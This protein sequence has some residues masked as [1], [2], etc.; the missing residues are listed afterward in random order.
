MERIKSLS[1][2][3]RNA[4]QYPKD[5]TK[6][7]VPRDGYVMFDADYSQIEYR[8]LVAMAKEP[9]LA[10]MFKDPDT[11]YHTLMAS[12]MYGVPYAAVTPQMRSDAKS[13]NFGIPYGMG[14]KSLAILLTGMCGP[15]Q[16]AEAKAKYELYFKD[17]PNVK[18]FFDQV[19]EMAEVN[20]YTKTFWNRYRYYSFTDKDG[21]FSNARRA[22]ALRQAGNAVIQGCVRGDTLIQT[23][24]Y[25]IVQI[26][27]V[28]DQH[29][30]IW[31]GTKWTNG[32]ILY[33]G[34]K[35][36]CIVTFS[37][38]QRFIC[39]PTHKFL[40]R[41]HKGN[42]RF[43]ECQNIRDKS[44]GTN[45]HRVVMSQEFCDSDWA[46][47]SNWARGKYYSF[48]NNANNVFVDDIGDSFKAG[49]VLGRLASDGS[50]FLRD[51]GG[52]SIRQIIAEHEEIITNDLLEYMD[53]LNPQ[54]T[55]NNVRK[56]RNQA[57][58]WIEVYSKTLTN[59]I[60]DLDIKHCVNKK[61]FQDTEM[62]RGFLR[63]LFDGDGGITGENTI[64]LVF[65]NQYNFENMC[66]DIQKA[67]TFIG[68]RSRYHRFADRYVIDISTYDNSRF[69]DYIGFMNPE[70]HDSAVH[71][72][73]K[74]QH[75]FGRVLIVESVEITDE[76]IDMYDVCNT[77]E[78]YYV[79]DG[80]V[81]HN[82]AAD[83]FKISVARNFCYIRQNGLL[84]LALIVN[85]VHDEQLF[86][87][88]CE[89][90]NIQSVFRDIVHNME[91]HVDGFPPLYIG[92]GFGPNWKEAKGKMAEIHPALAEQLS[93]E[94][95]QA[96]IFT[97]DAHSVKEVLEYFDKRVYEFREKKVADYLMN[98]DN[99]KKDIHP[100]I[101]SL[102]NLQFTYGL[103]EKYSG[104]E[105]LLKAIEE[106]IK[107]NNIPVDPNNFR[108]TVEQVEEVEE[109]EEYDDNED[110]DIDEV[111]AQQ[112][113][114]FSL[115]DE[116]ESFFGVS[117]QDLIKEFGLVV[118]KSRRVCGIDVTILPL[119]QKD[120]LADFLATHEADKDDMESMQ[121]VFLQ[122]SNVLFN[123]GVFVK[124]FTG[125][126]LAKKLSLKTVLY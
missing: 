56:G 50:I 117:V 28:V 92:A 106:F 11:D 125:E 30:Q 15:T 21:K 101:G 123:T 9:M 17:Q 94:V 7:V 66:R 44:T 46:Y 24:E 10:E 35:R 65:G 85:M 8:T 87:L 33:S 98:P 2:N 84:G 121:V 107:R 1:D 102:I 82:T 48:S 119:K 6:L 97:T 39:S 64:R 26:Q 58:D 57:V 76:Y 5:I 96:P 100:V 88:N 95:A 118:S 43:V 45:S 14:F 81:T 40:V 69:L 22:S 61:I 126:Q 110:E 13:F 3:M 114:E 72:P 80:I 77:D 108:K 68:I 115:I 62:L 74:D 78:G 116:N 47:S 111:E 29:L 90:L 109:D 60:A 113:S 59:E 52:S 67:L 12:L 70:K 42:D 103:E 27:D 79:A 18:R 122:E 19:K 53:N 86:E 51:I 105:L 124:G 91:F 104:E 54:Y 41:S 34:K 71:I 93:Q 16:V 89:Q 49:V 112:E 63:G 23:K 38:G 4:Q 36:K 20:K 25:G 75:I 73:A 83:I 37:T 55:R 99:F 120:N 32:D 31:N